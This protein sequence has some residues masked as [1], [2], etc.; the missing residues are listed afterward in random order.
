MWDL[1]WFYWEWERW[2]RNLLCFAPRPRSL[3]WQATLYSAVYLSS[4][5][6]SKLFTKFPLVTACKQQ[7]YPVF[8]YL[9][10]SLHFTTFQHSSSQDCILKSYKPRINF[11]NY[12]IP[13]VSDHVINSI[14][15]NSS[16]E[17]NHEIPPNLHGKN[18]VHYHMSP[19]SMPEGPH[20]FT[21]RFNIMLESTT[22][23]SMC[24]IPF[25][26]LK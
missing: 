7:A 23:V 13:S 8:I 21:T 12:I 26:F 24:S 10:S 15:Q 2:V 14:V 11:L 25:K 20:L 18:T 22:S 4:F 9:V 1:S 6:F 3:S 16:W 17:C 5:H 19:P